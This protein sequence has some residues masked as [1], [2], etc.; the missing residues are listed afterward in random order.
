MTA[1]RTI[2]ARNARRLAISS[3][4][5]AGQQPAANQDDIH[6]L[7]NHLGCVQIDPIRAV[8][9][10][11]LL[12]LWSRLGN[13]D[14]ADLDALLWQ[15][16]RLFEY[17]AHAASIVLTEDYPIYRLHMEN[18]LNGD[19][20][21]MKRTRD[22][23]EENQELRQSILNGLAEN[24]P[25]S[26]RDFKDRSE[27]AWQSSGW[28]SGQNV[29]LMIN[30]LWRLGSI[31][32]SHRKGLTKF[33]ELSEQCLPEWTPRDQLDWPEAVKMAA[34]RSLRALGLARAAH[35]EQHFTRGRYPGLES[36]LN[37]LEDEGQIVQI[38]IKDQG[39]LWPSTWYVHAKD[40]P[41][42][43]RLEAGE[44]QPRTVLLSPF[45]NLICDRDRTEFLF[46]FH[47]RIEIYVPKAKRKYGYYVLPMLHGDS[48]IGR[49]DAKMDRK[50]HQLHINA[51]YAEPEAPQDVGT[52]QAV[53][54]TVEELAEFLGAKEIVYG[55]VQPTG[56]APAFD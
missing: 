13:F 4:R 11:Q 53:A 17:W 14:T 48:L 29:G 10:T 33:W 44:W 3:Q 51:V 12:V 40:L 1:I 52:G 24:G 18:W 22:W 31:M 5:L 41:L 2:S 23:M 30:A 49:L 20:A 54:G 38:Q 16:R 28:T 9:R 6:E 43:D 56:W 25:L 35:I 32:V 19:K 21:W 37:E 27:R 15:E 45:D 50:K 42:V 47:F 8:E 26:S 36:V 55:Q 39:Q 7:I 34:Q 46:D